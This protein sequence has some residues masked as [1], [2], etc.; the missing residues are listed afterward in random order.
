MHRQRRS[1][2][3]GEI[4]RSLCI[5]SDDPA[6]RKNSAWPKR[7]NCSSADTRHSAASAAA[8]PELPRLARYTDGH[9]AEL[10]CV[11]KEAVADAGYA[12]KQLDR[13]L[14]NHVLALIGSRAET[15][16][17]AI[18]ELGEIYD[19]VSQVMNGTQGDPVATNTNT[20]LGLMREI[21]AIAGNAEGRD[22]LNKARAGA[23]LSPRERQIVDRHDVL[24]KQHNEIAD[25]E[26]A[27]KGGGWLKGP[28]SYIPSDAMSWI[29]NPNKEQRC[30]LAAEWKARTLNDRSHAYWDASRGAEHKSAVLAMK[31][32]YEAAE[33]GEINSVHLGPD[34][35]VS[36]EE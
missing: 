36:G 19:G 1:T 32:A 20:D 29:T 17:E 33:T 22:A 34:G 12:A 18:T 28:R 30:Q 5:A 27:G 25:A 21:A 26:R 3:D 10:A 14:A 16:N 35:T 9:R 2:P 23:S 13:E 8:A 24:L 15:S 7:F 4:E 31:A 6:S 11:L